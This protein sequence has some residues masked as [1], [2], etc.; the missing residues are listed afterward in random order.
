MPYALEPTLQDRRHA[1]DER[2]GEESHSSAERLDASRPRGGRPGSEMAGATDGIRPVRR[3]LDDRCPVSSVRWELANG[4]RLSPHAVDPRGPC[5]AG[6]LDERDGRPA[7][8]S[9]DRNHPPLL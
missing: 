2:Y 9:A 6:H 8:G 3:R 5:G 7:T 1:G 4:P